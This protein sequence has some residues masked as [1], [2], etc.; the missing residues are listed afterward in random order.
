MEFII[1]FIAHLG[2]GFVFIVVLEN[3][4]EEVFGGF[5]IGVAHGED[6]GVGAL[7]EQLVLQRVTAAVA[8]DDAAHLPEADVVEE[9]TARDANFA[10]E[11][12]I[13]VV[14]GT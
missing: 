4:W 9:L 12:L 11:Q 14:G 8:S 3:A 1:L 7:G 6:G 13:D 2:C 10:H 5:P